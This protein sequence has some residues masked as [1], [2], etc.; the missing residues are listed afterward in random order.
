VTFRGKTV[1]FCC[2]NCP[3]TFEADPT[4]FL[5]GLG[6]EDLPTKD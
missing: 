6:L 4:P 1:G 2:P 3:R 5:A